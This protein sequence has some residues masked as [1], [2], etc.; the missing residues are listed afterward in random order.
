MAN[1]SKKVV[2]SARIDPFLKSGMD[3]LSAFTNQKIVK[4][5]ETLIENGLN[6]RVVKN[7]FSDSPENK[8]LPLMR[9]LKAVWSEDEILYQLRLG[10]LSRLGVKCTSED[11]SVITAEVLDNER[12][13]G[14]CDLF[15]GVTGLSK[16]AGNI[17]FK[18]MVDIGRVRDEWKSL[19]TYSMFSRNNR[20]L[21]IS[22]DQF[23]IVV[24]IQR[25]YS[26]VVI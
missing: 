9:L 4:L 21:A 11:V 7:P 25:D 14:E 17:R 6:D 26:K 8:D 1:R 16:E 18:Y 2:L 19:N 13:K 15:D 23:L 22:Y 24:G 3:A 5:L 10:V 12:F 20:P